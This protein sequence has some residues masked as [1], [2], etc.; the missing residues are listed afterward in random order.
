M[1]FLQA[2]LPL[3]DI[4]LARRMGITYSILENTAMPVI[5]HSNSR[6]CDI[7]RINDVSFGLLSCPLRKKLNTAQPS[8]CNVMRR[9]S[10]QK[11]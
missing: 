11:Q 10:S 8:T 3:M 6:A 4:L 9:A 7:Y 1:Y 2:T 5:N